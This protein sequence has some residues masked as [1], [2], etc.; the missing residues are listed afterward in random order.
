VALGLAAGAAAL[1][2]AEVGALGAMLAWPARCWALRSPA[3][4]R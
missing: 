2:L 3:P 1:A 4:R